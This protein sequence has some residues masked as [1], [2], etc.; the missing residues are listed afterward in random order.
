MSKLY[1]YVCILAFLSACKPT[2]MLEVVQ[3]ALITLPDHVN[4]LATIDRSKP[5]SGFVNVL[6]GGATGEAIHQDRDGRRNA[7]D[8]LAETLSRTPR[9]EVIHTGLEY[10]GTET[11][12]T[13]ATPLPWE[14]IASICS[15]YDAD[16]VIAIEKFDTD[17]RR[18]VTSRK[19][20][21]KKDD[22]EIEVTV[23]DGTLEVDVHLGWRIYDLKTR[24]I[25][26]EVDV[27]DGDNDSR[28]GVETE[29]E[30]VDDLADPRELT[31]R[32]SQRAG[33]KYGERIAPI[34]IRVNRSFFKKVKGPEQEEMARAARLFE[35]DS[36]N[37]AVDIW[38]DIVERPGVN[39]EVKGMTAYN[40]A[41]AYEKRGMLPTALDWAQNAYGQHGNKKARSY[42]GIL[43]D[44]IHDQ[45]ILREQMKQRS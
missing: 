5:S 44:R 43:K 26:D 35:T 25:I 20:K 30:L 24:R 36:W 22:K 37:E 4:V 34:W 15:K 29:K 27:S 28:S 2:T 12:S 3:P 9:F 33:K 17:N 16:A 40:L 18:E 14:E 42:V 10:T 45:E 32:V 1:F 6:E 21:V 38:H 31:Y 13:F 8:A 7:L 11:G 19:K 39:S 23:Y 41:V